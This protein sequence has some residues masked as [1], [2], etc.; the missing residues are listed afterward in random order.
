MPAGGASAGLSSSE[1][2]FVRD[3]VLGWGSQRKL[4]SDCK[5]DCGVLLDCD[6]VSGAGTLGGR[7]ANLLP[8][9]E[10]IA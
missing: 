6:M 5:S 3:A 1:V 7:A 8:M 2:L 9:S 10:D 4:K